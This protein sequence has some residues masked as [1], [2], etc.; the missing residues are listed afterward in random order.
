MLRVCKYIFLNFILKSS[1]LL[2]SKDLIK[3][4]NGFPLHLAGIIQD[5]FLVKN[6]DSF[7]HNH[8]Y[9]MYKYIVP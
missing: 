7:Y 6:H 3:K 4:K 5:L 8:E 9:V 2:A 1:S